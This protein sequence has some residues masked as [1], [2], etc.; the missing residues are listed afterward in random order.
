MNNLK[1]AGVQMTYQI[2]SE[3]RIKEPSSGLKVP[4]DIYKLLARYARCRQ[5]HFL[6][7]TLNGNHEPL[8][9]VIVSIGTA[10]RTLVHPRDVLYPA[11]KDNA[12]ALIVAHNHPSGNTDPSNEDMEITEKLSG[13]CNIL[14]IRLL[15][16]LIISR[17]G[18]YSFRQD[19]RLE[20]IES[21]QR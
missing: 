6:C 7:V 13:A 5:E 14:G 9:I 11:I 20:E 2:V 10:N 4:A 12:V 8:S 15:D 16:H 18:F 17:K 1:N 21:S 3:R 19:G